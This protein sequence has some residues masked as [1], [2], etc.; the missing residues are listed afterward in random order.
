MKYFRKQFY[1]WE[2][3][4]SLLHLEK[5]NTCV[6]VTMT[7]TQS[8]LACKVETLSCVLNSFSLINVVLLYVLQGQPSLFPL[9]VNL[10]RANLRYLVSAKLPSRISKSLYLRLWSVIGLNRESSVPES[11]WDT[12]RPGWATDP[13]GSRGRCGGLTT[14]RA[15]PPSVGHPRC[16]LNQ[17]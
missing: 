17:K 16:F 7:L 14:P 8:G 3:I 9:S 13:C 6:C 12:W 2:I 4:L 1:I 15:F 11:G 10:S 5:P